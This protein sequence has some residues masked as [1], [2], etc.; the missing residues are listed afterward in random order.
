MATF[1]EN[2]DRAQQLVFDSILRHSLAVERNTRGMTA[3]MTKVV[4]AAGAALGP[5][6]QERLDNLNQGEL[7]ALMRYR[8]GT[9][10]DKLP[11][12]VQS[13][14]SFIAAWSDDLGL[15]ISSTWQEGAKEFAQ[16]EIDFVSDLM[17]EALEDVPKIGVT[18]A[19]VYRQAMAQPVMGVF[20]DD[21]LREEST[22]TRYRVYTTIRNGVTQGQT[23]AEI[24]R[25]LRGTKSMNYTDGELKTTRNNLNSIVRTGRSHI[26]SI[27]E[28]EVYDALGVDELV[29]IATLD[30]RTTFICSSYDSRVFKRS[31]NSR[32]RLPLHWGE[33]SRYAPYFGGKIAG[34]RPYVK[35][36]E[37]IQRIRKNDRPE[38]MIGQVRASTSMNE[39]LKRP[40]NSAFAREY[41]GDTRYRLFKEGKLDIR[42]MV[43]A[44]GTKYSIAELRQRYAKDFREVFGDAG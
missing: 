16:A 44:D 22:K 18:A 10:V 7:T 27:A 37:P 5:E 6:L 3:E 42:Q 31:D 1:E 23:N 11:T 38:G 2:R 8:P 25:A 13:V 32:P 36:F 34:N 35:A 4:E 39:F 41:F 21:A 9:K 43:R 14:I 30:G 19:A 20:L 17:R 29:F 12:R 26:A 40:D 28:E 33:R 15:A 24:V